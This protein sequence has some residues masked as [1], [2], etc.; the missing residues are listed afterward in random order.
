[1]ELKLKLSAY[2][3]YIEIT[4]TLLKRLNMAPFRKKLITFLKTIFFFFVQHHLT[5]VDKKYFFCATSALFL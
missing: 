5:F 1:M 2:L 4:E 3:D